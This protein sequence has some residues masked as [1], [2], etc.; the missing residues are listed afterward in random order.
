MQ[1]YLISAVLSSR[2]EG[3]TTSDKNVHAAAAF[4]IDRVPWCAWSW[5]P[6]PLPSLVFLNSAYVSMTRNL[7]HVVWKAICS[8]MIFALIE[9]DRV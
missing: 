9:S 6:P 7:I 2:M 1:T 5:L 4:N 3:A 8:L